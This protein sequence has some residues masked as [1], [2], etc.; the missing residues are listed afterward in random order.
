MLA[1]VYEC[2]E[3]GGW[4]STNM[5]W[6]RYLPFFN[7]LL[8]IE[9]I[10]KIRKLNY[11]WPTPCSFQAIGQAGRTLSYWRVQL[12]ILWGVKMWQKV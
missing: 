10:R 1:L 2:N 12:T 8:R 5:A 9:Q 6:G 7:C 4:K 3:S 11:D